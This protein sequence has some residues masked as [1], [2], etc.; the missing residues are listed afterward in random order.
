MPFAKIWKKNKWD[1]YY[2]VNCSWARGR[3]YWRAWK[4]ADD[5]ITKPF[6]YPVLEAR[7]RSVLKRSKNIQTNN[8]AITIHGLKI[9]PDQEKPI[10]N[11][12]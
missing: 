5:Y 3:H 6:S 11:S 1:F 7:I 8:K 12:L 10:D 4:W 2:N 9:D